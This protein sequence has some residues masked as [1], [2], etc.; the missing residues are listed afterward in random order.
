[1]VAVYV[2][3]R[4]SLRS[5]LKLEAQAFV[6]GARI[7][8]GGAE[9]AWRGEMPPRTGVVTMRDAGGRPMSDGSMLTY[10]RTVLGGGG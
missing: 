1:M 8:V 7:C 3:V 2:A 4:Y 9:A 10:A 5:S 6:V